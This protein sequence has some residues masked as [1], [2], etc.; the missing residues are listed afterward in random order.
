MTQLHWYASMCNVYKTQIL[1][2]KQQ[3]EAKKKKQSLAYQSTTNETKRNE[4]KKIKSGL[5][6]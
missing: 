6:F 4:K 1:T 5:G 3:R 2:L